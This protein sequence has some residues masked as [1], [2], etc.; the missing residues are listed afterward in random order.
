M[1]EDDEVDEAGEEFFGEY[2][3]FF[4][5]LAEVVEAG[6]LEWRSGV[7]GVRCRGG[8]RMGEVPM[9]RVRKP[10]PRRMPM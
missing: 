7:S 4:D 10:K 5:E 2:G 3:V 9:E 6:C 1:Q 8:K